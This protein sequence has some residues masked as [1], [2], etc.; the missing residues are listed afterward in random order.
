MINF[1]NKGKTSAHL[2]VDMMPVYISIFE[3]VVIITDYL[4]VLDQLP[5][6]VDRG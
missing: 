4:E 1:H 5:L 2:A 3:M 6:M